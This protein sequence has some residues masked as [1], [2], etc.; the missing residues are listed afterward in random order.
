V[1]APDDVDHPENWYGGFYELAINL[2]PHDD[3]RLEE[4]L[5]A[6]WSSAAVDGC[7]ARTQD[8]LHRS[9]PCSLDSLEQHGHL[10]GVVTCP[11]GGRVVCGVW[12][13]REDDGDDWLDFALPLGALERDPRV[14]AFPFGDDGGAVSREWREPL[15]SWLGDVGASVYQRVPFGYAAIGFEASGLSLVELVGG[16]DRYWPVLRP[17]NGGLEL[18]PVTRWDFGVAG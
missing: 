17:T 4:A 5:V 11:D 2:G 16:S 3:A 18:L 15:D 12:V 1:G 13:V 10:R 14:G 9:V 7:L 6:V 8:P